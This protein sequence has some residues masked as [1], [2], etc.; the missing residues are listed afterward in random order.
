MHQ[1]TIEQSI[2]LHIREVNTIIGHKPTQDAAKD[3]QVG[4]LGMHRAMTIIGKHASLLRC[5]RAQ[6]V[7]SKRKYKKVPSVSHRQGFVS[8]LL[9]FPPFS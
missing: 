3:M 8:I 5:M 9:S 6:D 2:D 7:E 4:I 1:T